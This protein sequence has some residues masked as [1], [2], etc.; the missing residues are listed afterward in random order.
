MIN[1]ILPILKSEPFRRFSESE[2]QSQLQPAQSLPDI[3]KAMVEL[4]VGTEQGIIG[5]GSFSLSGGS[6]MVKWL[7]YFG[8]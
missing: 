2:L 5:E 1:Q 6:P 7:S 8:D 3:N 4:Y